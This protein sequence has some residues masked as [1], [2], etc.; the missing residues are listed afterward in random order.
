MKTSIII[1]CLFLTTVTKAQWY[2]GT[3]LYKNG[4]SEKGFIK[5]FDN[6]RRDEIYFRSPD[7]KRK[8]IDSKKLKEIQFIND[9]AITIT[10]IRLKPVTPGAPLIDFLTESSYT[11]FSVYYRGEFDV[12]TQETGIL[13]QYIHLPGTDTAVMIKIDYHGSGNRLT[14][15][16]FHK[17]AIEIF[18]DKCSEMT[19]AIE[20][21]KFLPQSIDELIEYYEKKCATIT[22]CL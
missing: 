2:E 4:T 17:A 15:D 9:K 20:Q 12:V 18:K 3:L 16:A 22:T 13:N 7:G 8:N 19:R 14:L 21:K 1:L 5:Y 11:W 6:A 10:Y